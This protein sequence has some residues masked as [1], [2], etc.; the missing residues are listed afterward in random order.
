MAKLIITDAENAKRECPL[1]Q[2]LTIG[3]D[4]GNHIQINERLASRAHCRLRMDKG[5]FFL[6]DLKSSNGT[7]VNGF[8]LDTQHEMR[9]GDVVKIGETIIL[10]DDEMPHPEKAQ[11]AP[12]E[13]AQ[14]AFLS[15]AEVEA[16][17]KSAHAAYPGAALNGPP[18]KSKQ[19]AFPV[20]APNGPPSK[21]K[22]KPASPRSPLASF[23]IVCMVAL[24]LLAAAT[25]LVDKS[26][27]EKLLRQLRD[28]VAGNNSAPAI[29]APA[30]RPA[31]V[32]NVPAPEVTPP[33][34]PTWEPHASALSAA[35]QKKEEE[36]FLR[37]LAKRDRALDSNNFLR[38]KAVL[39]EF[40]ALHPAG[41]LAGRAQQELKDTVTVA[42]GALAATLK[43]AAKAIETG[44]NRLATQLCTRVLS[45][46]PGGACGTQARELLTKLDAA[47]ERR[48]KELDAKAQRE[49]KAGDLNQA[50]ETLIKAQDELG[51]TKW[52]S[53]ISDAQLRTEMAG[54]LL[55]RL[56]NECHKKAAA[57]K[58]IPFS[59]TGDKKD[60]VVEGV[61]GLELKLQN[62][63]ATIMMGLKKIPVAEFSKILAVAGLSGCHLELACLW[64]ILDRNEDARA[65]AERALRDPE[66]AV[67]ATRL[68]GLLPSLK[69]LH[70]YD[71]SKWQQQDDWEAKTG[72]W[73]TEGGR[74]VLEP[75]EGGD[76]SLKTKALDGDFELKNA[77]LSFDFELSQPAAGYFFSFEI[78]T[79]QRVFGGNFSADGLMLYA[80]LAQNTSAKGVWNGHGAHVDLAVSDEN[81]TVALNGQPA[82]ELVV[83][84]ISDL[85][86]T[87]SFHARATGCA[88]SKVILRNE[89]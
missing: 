45:A 28:V 73:S 84:G 64:L 20:Q 54:S 43:D 75:S 83:P 8:K 40:L 46:D 51:G 69:K 33:P 25:A 5:K 56:N 18:S 50:G 23:F 82:L 26:T 66:Q 88:I 67:T 13:K 19:P 78:G 22:I 29:Q 76:T 85:A 65:E 58:A 61:F 44:R 42:E 71:F 80:N 52:G 15:P 27:L 62:E 24:L 14:T 63:G 4:S 87:L 31:P 72:S 9:H 1:T 36:D 32:V 35:A 47:T 79:E 81:V 57:G 12:P 11:T 10:F 59:L 41:V 7:F 6:T 2:G 86:G 17:D 38:A 21:S 60:A 70:I 77:R 89:D 3:R 39:N 30:P 49:V 74:Y 37:A 53:L 55:T 68:A 48:F 34:V 16:L